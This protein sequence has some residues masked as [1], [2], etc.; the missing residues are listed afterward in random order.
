ME[1][2]PAWDT[3]DGSWGE[4][5]WVVEEEGWNGREE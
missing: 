3:V 5:E 2:D 1:A 4:M